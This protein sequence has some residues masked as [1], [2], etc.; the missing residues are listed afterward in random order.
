MEIWRDIKGYEGLY[1][2]SNLGRVKSLGRIDNLGRHWKQRILRGGLD[3]DGYLITI[4][5]KN[6]KSECFKVHRLV[7]QAFLQNYENLP[8]INHI[9]EN[10]ENNRVENLEWCTAKYN[11]NFGT[12]KERYGTRDIAIR[13]RARNEH[14]LTA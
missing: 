2:V 3:K 10:K 14:R 13:I 8:Q 1:Q 12:R 6:I 7:A 11:S 4:L 9:D 5:R